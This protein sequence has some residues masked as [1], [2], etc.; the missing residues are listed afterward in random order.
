MGVGPE[1]W[2]DPV[3]QGAQPGPPQVSA[4]RTQSTRSVRGGAPP[5]AGAKGWVAPV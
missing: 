2:W 3:D 5:S 1:L 4:P